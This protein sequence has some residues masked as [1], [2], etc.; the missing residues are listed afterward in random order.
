MRKHSSWGG[1]DTLKSLLLH[2]PFWAQR[3]TR[4]SPV[5]PELRLPY[6]LC[7]QLAHMNTSLDIL[8]WLALVTTLSFTADTG[9][10][11]SAASTLSIQDNDGANDN[12]RCHVRRGASVFLV[13]NSATSPHTST[14]FKAVCRRGFQ[15][16][17]QTP[18]FSCRYVSCLITQ[19][20]KAVSG[21][22]SPFINWLHAPKMALIR[23]DLFL[24]LKALFSGKDRSC[25]L[26][27]PCPGGRQTVLS[28]RT[29]SGVAQ[30]SLHP[31]TLG[32]GCVG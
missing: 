9:E 11:R 20:A 23:L 18:R 21:S 10:G 7:H 8:L 1:G 32:R 27:E 12:A 17:N 30:V 3:H 28:L 2:L 19:T 26:P 22:P 6:Q 4:L 31:R 16:E 14:V 13:Q 25:R 15:G 29:I 5:G 24:S